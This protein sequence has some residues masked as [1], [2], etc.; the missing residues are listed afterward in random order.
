MKGAKICGGPQTIQ[1]SFRPPIRKSV[2]EFVTFGQKKGNHFFILLLTKT[3]RVHRFPN[4]TLKSVL[5][6]LSVDQK[7]LSPSRQN[8]WH[9][10]TFIPILNSPVGLSDLSSFPES[11]R[12]DPL[13]A[14]LFLSHLPCP[15]SHGLITPQAATIKA[16]TKAGRE[17]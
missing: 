4:E 6:F 16:V 1:L 11:S 13:L 5:S 15:L 12:P 7:F 2:S 17:R 10:K 9:C 8:S 3:P 14:P